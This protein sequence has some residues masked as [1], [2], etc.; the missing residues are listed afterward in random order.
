M[1]AER[2]IT[3]EK[4]SPEDSLIILLCCTTLTE[5]RKKQS[6]AL[7]KKIT[8][9]QGLYATALENK[10]LPLIYKH[11]AREFSNFIPDSILH[12]MRNFCTANSIRNLSMFNAL[13]IL[14][15]R[16]AK[17]GIEFISFKGPLLAGAIFGDIG[18]RIFS[19]LDL[20]VGE[21]QLGKAVTILLEDGF[22]FDLD[23]EQER[24]L[25]MI[26]NLHHAVLVK[27]QI[28]VEL[29][30]ELSGRYFWNPLRYE[31]LINHTKQVKIAS[32]TFT[33]LS[34]TDSLIYLAIH[35]CRH[36][37]NK[38][39]Y[40]VCIAES[41]K[42][43]PEL[44]WAETLERARQIGALHM[45]LLALGLAQELTLLKL[46]QKVQQELDKCAEIQNYCREYSQRTWMTKQS[47]ANNYRFYLR[48]NRHLLM[49]KR[50]WLAYALR[51]LLI[52]SYH[53]WQ[54]LNL[55]IYLAFLYYP[56]R[57]FRLFLV[58]LRTKAKSWNISLN[59]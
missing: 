37:W 2:T 14:Q 27:E 5:D 31:D 41:V 32:H 15:K 58:R 46:P 45:L 44:C 38:H 36:Y 59:K 12:M 57:P 33:V 48:Y 11:F 6:A 10:V 18:L 28:V 20:L 26:K 16:L 29:H 43:E 51:P 21:H 25:K 54:W 9:W 52:P 8:D 39:D 17:Q 34:P 19:D 23:M 4:Y 56:L 55:P 13:V 40:I 49:K 42:A 22:V 7:I 24:Y 30:W 1:Y 3:I 53:D 35:G 50:D 47:I